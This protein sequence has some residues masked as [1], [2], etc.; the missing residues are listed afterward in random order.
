MCNK[1]DPLEKKVINMDRQIDLVIN[2]KE[3]ILN[4]N[5]DFVSVF[6]YLKKVEK[7]MLKLIDM[8]RNLF[9]QQKENLFKIWV[10]LLFLNI[11]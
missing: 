1:V 11:M 3:N 9:T 10:L 6:K 2:N 8:Q 5:M 7:K 4:E